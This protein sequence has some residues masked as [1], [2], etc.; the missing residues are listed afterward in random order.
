MTQTLTEG[1]KE[2]VHSKKFSLMIKLRMALRFYMY[3]IYKISKKSLIFV[4]A[5]AGVVYTDLTLQEFSTWLNFMQCFSFTAI[6]L[7][8]QKNPCIV[9][10]TIFILQDWDIKYFHNNCSVFLLSRSLVDDK[11]MKAVA[12]TLL[13]L[14]N[15]CL[16]F[17]ILL[18]GQLLCISV[19]NQIP[20]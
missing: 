15:S 8:K 18:A 20:S 5:H 13:L 2:S 3:L 7:A 17:Q 14:F 9:Y 19:L 11:F 1:R 16:W 12:L 6:V 10:L 4:S